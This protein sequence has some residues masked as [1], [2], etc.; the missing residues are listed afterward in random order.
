[1]SR[2]TVP[3]GIRITKVGLW[4]IV[5]TVLVAIPAANTGNNSLYLV[6]ACLLALLVVSGV[7]SRQNLRR[8]DIELVPPAEV[9]ARQPFDLAFRVCHSGWI[10]DRRLLVIAGIGEG[11]PVLV[12]HLVKG[13]VQDGH[14]ELMVPKRGLLPIPYV[15]L[16][17]IYPLGLFRKGMRYRSD[18]ELLVYP[19]I[20]DAPASRYRGAGPAGDRP[21]FND[22]ATTEI[23]TLRKFRPGDDRRGVHW[24]QTARTGELIFMEREA[25]KGQRVS[26]LF[27][28]NVPSSS[29]PEVAEAFELVVSEVAT[30]ASYL[31]ERGFEVEL[32]TRGEIVGFGRGPQHRRRMLH[33]LALI[34][35]VVDAGLPLVGS[36][37]S[38]PTLNFEIGT[39]DR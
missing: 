29:D 27:D 37:P 20:L 10:W 34:A 36:D 18:I 11:K 3:E 8:L 23:Y 21:F 32:I 19:Q 7:T 31:N 2:Q 15:H 6:E 30:A 12:Q 28:N 14:L 13:E 39:V 4:Y 17:S 22:T 1:M 5:L 35:P 16:S 38:A 24:K 25:E 26:L 33:S 9:Y